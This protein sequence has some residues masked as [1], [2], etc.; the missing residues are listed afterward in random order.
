MPKD[1]ICY[2]CIIWFLE[3]RLK[4]VSG[5]QIKQQDYDARVKEI[6][7]ETTIKKLT[8]ESSK[9]KN[10][11]LSAACDL[12]SMYAESKAA[13]DLVS[14]LN[15]TL[16]G[17]GHEDKCIRFETGLMESS[18]K[19]RI[20]QTQSESVG[21]VS[22]SKRRRYVDFEN[23]DN[24]SVGTIT[25]EFFEFALREVVTEARLTIDQGCT[26]KQAAVNKTI[27]NAIDNKKFDFDSKVDDKLKHITGCWKGI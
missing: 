27:I 12:N 25:R 19:D 14:K 23:T 13:R 11:Y 3:Q 8:A 5:K 24:T 1:K 9:Y 6:N 7:Y 18:W 21:P 22:P 17:L 10:M 2:E 20:L 15:S 4:T 26:S 16:K